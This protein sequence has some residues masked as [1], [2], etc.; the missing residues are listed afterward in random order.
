VLGV[1][2]VD[3]WGFADSGM[4]GPAPA[5]SLAAT[6]PDDL[7]QAVGRCVDGARPDALLTLDASDDHRDHLALRTAVETVG[8]EASL[9]TYLSCLPRTLMARWADHVART[10][11]DS[12]YLALGERGTPDAALTHLLD[13]GAHLARR[14]AAIAAHQSQASP[15]EDLPDDLRR[16]FLAT[17]HLRQVQTT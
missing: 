7:A 13:A 1:A 8:R 6:D 15:F 5:G 17:V 11:R 2:R 16:A 3:V 9:P 10:E 4:A 14:E 12:A